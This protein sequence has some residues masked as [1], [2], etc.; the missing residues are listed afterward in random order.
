MLLLSETPRT[1]TAD[2]SPV[3]V[4]VDMQ[5]VHNTTNEQDVCNGRL[6]LKLISMFNVS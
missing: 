5:Y 6:T 2:L 3:V 4:P 1:E